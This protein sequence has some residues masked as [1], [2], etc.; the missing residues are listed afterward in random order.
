MGVKHHENNVCKHEAMGKVCLSRGQINSKLLWCISDSNKNTCEEA[1][2]ERKP[3]ARPGE[4]N[5]KKTG[6]NI[7]IGDFDF[8]VVRRTITHMHTDKKLVPARRKHLPITNEKINFPG[9]SNL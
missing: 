1:Q 8:C 4:E 3:S 7:I 2:G 9:G 5:D 6:K